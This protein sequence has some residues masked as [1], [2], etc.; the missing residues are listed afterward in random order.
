[1]IT[2]YM[3]VEIKGEDYTVS[4]NPDTNVIVCMGSLR[5]AGK[6]EYAP[7][8]D[9]LDSILIDCPLS[10]IMDLS[11]LQFLNSSG[12]NI[13]SKFVIQVRKQENVQ[14]TVKGAINIPWQ[15]KSLKNLQR[16]MPALKLECLSP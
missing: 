5:L 7:V 16:L 1:M 3:M 10:I 13:L 14:L 12:I 2:E 6:E 4:Y 8:T 9:L 11:H 15:G